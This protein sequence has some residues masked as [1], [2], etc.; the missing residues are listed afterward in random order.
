MKKVHKHYTEA[1]T[2]ETID[3]LQ[4]KINSAK[5][6]GLRIVGI[7]HHFDYSSRLWSALVT[8]EWEEYVE[9]D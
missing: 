3:E 7:S 6:K 2:A 1:F 5:D 9:E 4:D 8:Y